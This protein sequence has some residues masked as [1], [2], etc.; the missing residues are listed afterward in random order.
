MPGLPALGELQ[1]QNWQEFF[2]AHREPQSSHRDTD[3]A[4]SSPSRPSRLVLSLGHSEQS[5]VQVSW[6]EAETTWT[7]LRYTINATPLLIQ[8]KPKYLLKPF[9]RFCRNC[10]PLSGL[11]YLILDQIHMSG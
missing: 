6:G 3:P 4:C 11:D 7:L 5:T 2:S 9:K 8:F 10:R 1:T